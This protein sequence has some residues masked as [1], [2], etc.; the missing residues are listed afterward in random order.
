MAA[1][2]VDAPKAPRE[3]TLSTHAPIS[4][5]S[6]PVGPQNMTRPKHRRT[7]TGFG[8][9]DIKAVESSIPEHMRDEWRKYVGTRPQECGIEAD[10]CSLQKASAAKKSSR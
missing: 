1:A 4:A 3:R 7:A 5:F 10:G 8:P 9:G 6:Q 2:A